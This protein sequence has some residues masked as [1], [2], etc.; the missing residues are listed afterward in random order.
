M[1]NASNSTA[2]YAEVSSL[3]KIRI[4]LMLRLFFRMTKTWIIISD[5]L[6]Q[7]IDASRLDKC[8]FGQ[9]LQRHYKYHVRSDSISIPE[10]FCYV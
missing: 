6:S 3:L 10:L 8:H 9:L 4:T 7:M 5:N 1:W 2:N